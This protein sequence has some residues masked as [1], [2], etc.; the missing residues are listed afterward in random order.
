MT[1]PEITGETS[2]GYHTF[3]ELYEHRLALTV[4][5]V[6]KT[7]DLAWRS[8]R[9]HVGGDPMFDGYFIVGL[10]LPTGTIT[11]HYDLKHWELFDAARTLDNAP[12]WDGA[13]PGRQRDPAAGVAPRSEVAVMSAPGRIQLR[14]TAGWRKPEGATVVARPSKWGN[15]WVAKE[16][17]RWSDLF[18]GAQFVGQS[19]DPAWARRRAV[20]LFRDYLLGRPELV[21]EARRELAGRDLACWCPLMDANGDQVPCHATVLLEAANSQAG[22][23]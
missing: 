16:Y 17:A 6:R 13:P 12:A 18:D 11:Y 21:A 23:S 14:R 3:N 4:A 9:H 15:P 2:D 7:P 5:L 10:D 19:T 1:T 20:E 22:V 8:L